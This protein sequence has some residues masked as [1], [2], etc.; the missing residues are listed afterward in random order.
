MKL[1]TSAQERVWPFISKGRPL[2]CLLPTTAVT[3]QTPVRTFADVVRTTAVSQQ[4]VCLHMQLRAT[5]TNFEN[6]S[7]IPVLVGAQSGQ[8]P[9][10]EQPIAAQ[11]IRSDRGQPEHL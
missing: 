8:A 5:L 11:Q 1:V 9:S 6:A 3:H 2:M 10:T 4:A 7:V